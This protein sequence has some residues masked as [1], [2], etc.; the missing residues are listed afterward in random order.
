MIGTFDAISLHM[1]NKDPVKI[2]TSSTPRLL[3]FQSIHKM[4]KPGALI[5]IT[6][7]NWTR[8]EIESWF[9]MVGGFTFHSAIKYPV[10][11]FGG[12]QGS[13]ICSVAFRKKTT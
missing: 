8:L 2:Q 4:M 1:D 9:N 13:K 10:F 7:C 11:S 6:S 3:Y 12:S 5:L